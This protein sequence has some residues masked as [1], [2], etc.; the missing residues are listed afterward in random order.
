M[1]Q[2]VVDKFNEFLNKNREKYNSLFLTNYREFGRKRISFD[3]I[4]SIVGYILEND[5]LNH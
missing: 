3:L 4:Y 5:F 2:K 1:Q